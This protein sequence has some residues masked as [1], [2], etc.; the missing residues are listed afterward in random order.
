MSRRKSTMRFRYF[1]EAKVSNA[2]RSELNPRRENR[3]TE[4]PARWFRGS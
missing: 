4:P 1:R 3:E 2:R